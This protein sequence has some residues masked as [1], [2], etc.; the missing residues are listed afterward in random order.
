MSFV[1][2]DDFVSSG[3]FEDLEW[4]NTVLTKKYCLKTTVIGEQAKCKKHVRVLNRLV[5]WHPGIGVTNEA[6]PRHVDI[7][8]KDTG[9]KHDKI[10]MVIGEREKQDL[11]GNW[12]EETSCTQS[13]SSSERCPSQTM[14]TSRGCVGWSGS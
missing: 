11:Y 13:R 1:Q 8:L 10:F 7:L 14:R 5:R 9:P 2:G 12:R 6:D 3:I 4:L